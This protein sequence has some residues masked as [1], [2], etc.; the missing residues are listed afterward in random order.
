MDLLK[1]LDNMITTED[2]A[3]KIYN[4]LSQSERSSIGYIST[5]MN[6]FLINAIKESGRI[7]SQEALKEASKV[8]NTNVDGD[9]IEH[10]TKERIL[11]S[12]PLDKIK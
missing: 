1:N 4:N 11:N 6:T 5:E 7:H 12:Y 3:N 2:I 9:Y 8:L 10:P